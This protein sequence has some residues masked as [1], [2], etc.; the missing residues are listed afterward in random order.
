MTLDANGTLL[1]EV[2]E[3]RV[4]D[5]AAAQRYALRAATLDTDKIK[6]VEAVA[7][8]S[9]AK[10]QISKASVSNLRALGRPF[11]W[12]YTLQSDDYAKPAGDL[13]LV[14]PRVIGSKARGILETK[15]PRRH[16]IEFKGLRHDSD[17]FEIRVPPG[18]ALD[19]LP[20]SVDVDDGFA[21]YHSKT[22]F[23]GGSLHYTR[24]FEIRELS[25]P[26]GKAEQLKKLYRI[27]EDDERNSAVL[28][29]ASK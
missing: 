12:H 11:E 20:P 3:V 17:T 13:L 15:E 21:A 28:K 25:V 8:I 22:E 6:P 1:G 10:F 29:R 7:G 23:S 16:S 9:L 26:V 19:E 18:Y 4:G 2:L 27:I 24:T 14:R 5:E